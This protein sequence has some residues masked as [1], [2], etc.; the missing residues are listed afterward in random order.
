MVSSHWIAPFP[1]PLSLRAFQ[2]LC[3]R[4]HIPVGI[5]HPKGGN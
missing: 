4:G 5:V 1:T 3:M 2:N